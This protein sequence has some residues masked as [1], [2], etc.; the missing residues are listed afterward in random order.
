MKNLKRSA[1]VLFFLIA[2]LSVFFAVPDRRDNTKQ[3]QTTIFVF[4]DNGDSGVY[5]VNHPSYASIGI[6]QSKGGHRLSTWEYCMFKG[7]LR[8]EKTLIYGVYRF[9]YR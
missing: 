9:E 6:H 4:F 7:F 2:L 1:F 5:T 3:V 8:C